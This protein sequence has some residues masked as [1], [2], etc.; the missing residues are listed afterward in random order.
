MVELMMEYSNTLCTVGQ[1]ILAPN[2]E[3]SIL[4]KVINTGG[5]DDA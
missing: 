2:L 4:I 1:R 5:E 3:S